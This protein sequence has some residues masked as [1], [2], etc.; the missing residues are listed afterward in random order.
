MNKLEGRVQELENPGSASSY[1][2][3]ELTLMIARS[4]KIHAV[5]EVRDAW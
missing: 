5:V 1:G 4:K 2:Q 3:N